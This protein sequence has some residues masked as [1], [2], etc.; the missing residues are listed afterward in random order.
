[1]NTLET[2]EAKLLELQEQE[3]YWR[4]REQSLLD[5]VQAAII[6]QSELGD[7]I[8]ALLTVINQMKSSDQPRRWFSRF[9]E[10]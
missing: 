5:A 2:M 7:E 8:H 10:R 9:N 4:L 3:R 6:R 1:M